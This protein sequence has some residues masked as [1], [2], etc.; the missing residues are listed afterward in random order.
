MPE[1]SDQPSTGERAGDARGSDVT[2]FNPIAPV[3]V[4]GG[5]VSAIK[6]GAQ[7]EVGRPDETHE[8][9]QDQHDRRGS[10]APA[11]ASVISVVAMAA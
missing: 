6:R 3:S 5:M 7:A 2:R 4:F 11:K 10:D 9:D 8:A 1:Q